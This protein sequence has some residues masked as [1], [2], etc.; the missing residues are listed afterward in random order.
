MFER[1]RG[2]EIVNEDL[3][4]ERDEL[5]LIIIDGEEE[6]LQCE[7]FWAALGGPSPESL[8]QTEDSRAVAPEADEVDM[9]Q[10]K[11][12]FRISDDS[13]T[14][15]MSM[16][17]EADELSA[18]DVNDSDCWGVSVDGRAYFY[19]GDGASY[20]EKISVRCHMPSVL[21]TM[22]LPRFAPTTVL[23][24]GENP[25]WDAIFSS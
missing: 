21:E 10:S 11:K 7:D 1:I 15:K 22:G 4:A 6:L 25:V 17:K 24:P 14:L 8:P 19:I 18:S 12:L 23:S 13:G 16:T 20:T 3:K 9:T 5:E 2:S